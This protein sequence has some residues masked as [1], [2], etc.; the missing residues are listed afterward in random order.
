MTTAKAEHLSAQRESQRGCSAGPYRVWGCR[1]R[2]CPCQRYSYTSRIP[3][4][5]HVRW[6]HRS[7]PCSSRHFADGER[8]SPRWGD[9][10]CRLYDTANIRVSARHLDPAAYL[11]ICNFPPSAGM[12][13][14]VVD[15]HLSFRVRHVRLRKVCQRAQQSVSG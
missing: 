7:D 3:S 12:V 10:P 4:V 2:H 13:S 11:S 14:K 1:A 9:R 15:L 8:R 5:C 6:R